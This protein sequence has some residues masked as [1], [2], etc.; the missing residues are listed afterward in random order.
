MT[1]SPEG[2]TIFL[3]R[4]YPAGDP[5]VLAI[6]SGAGNVQN[7][8]YRS[9]KRGLLLPMI[10]DSPT[11]VYTAAQAAA[12]IRS[13]LAADET[14]VGHM[15]Q[16]SDSVIVHASGAYDATVQ[17]H[18][19]H[20]VL[21]DGTSLLTI[22]FRVFNPDG[23]PNG[24]L[25]VLVAD[26]VAHQLRQIQLDVPLD[27]LRPTVRQVYSLLQHHLREPML[28]RALRLHSILGETLSQL[29]AGTAEIGAVHV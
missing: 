7:W 10:G 5:A 22:P 2:N 1:S 25:E 17:I 29:A 27:A 12:Y 19:D 23:S 8:Q 13:Q 24:A 18:G 15:L 26:D 9:G 11:A 21:M 3:N 6:A 20:T 4:G 16:S 28:L 14:M